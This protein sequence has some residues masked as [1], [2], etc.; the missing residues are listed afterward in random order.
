MNGFKITLATKANVR[1]ASDNLKNAL[2]ERF[3]HLPNLTVKDTAQIRLSQAF[4]ESSGI[5]GNKSISY[6]LGEDGKVYIVTVEGNEGNSF[7]TT[8]KGK[9]GRLNTSSE[10]FRIIQEAGMFPEGTKTAKFDLKL[11]DIQLDGTLEVYELVNYVKPEG[12]ED[13]EDED[14]VEEVVATESGDTAAL[15]EDVFA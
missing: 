11:T 10:L 4:F 6:G 7:K 5:S 8:E 12:A 15:E 14:E 3:K 2:R 1:T 13:V 9:K